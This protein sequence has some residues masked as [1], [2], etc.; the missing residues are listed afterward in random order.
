VNALPFS[1]GGA[2]LMQFFFFWRT[3]VGDEDYARASHPAARSSSPPFAQSEGHMTNRL[4]S[5]SNSLLLFLL[6]SLG[7]NGLSA[8]SGQTDEREPSSHAISCTN[9]EDDERTGLV[10]CEEGYWHR[11]TAH[12]CTVSIP[13][14]E[15]LTTTN[16]AD[17]CEFDSDCPGPYGYC[18][19]SGPAPGPFYNTCFSGCT[20]DDDCDQNQVCVCDTIV[21]TC[22][23]ATCRTDLDCED[24]SLC[25]ATR[26]STGSGCGFVFE[27]ACTGPGDEC[28]LDSDCGDSGIIGCISGE[29]GRACESLGACGRPFL[30]HGAARTSLLEERS[31]WLDESEA[32]FSDG[33]LSDEV[34]AALNKHFTRAGLMEHASIA[35]FARF[36]LQLLALGAPADLTVATNEAL[37]DETRH[38]RICFTLARRFGQAPLGPAALPVYGALDQFDMETTLATTLLEGCLGETSAAL[39]ARHASLCCT[40]ESIQNALSAIADDESRHAALAFRFVRFALQRNP[41]LTQTVVRFFDELSQQRFKETTIDDWTTHHDLRAY[42]VLSASERSA[43]AQDAARSIVV[44]T[45]RALLQEQETRRFTTPLGQQ[46]RS[47]QEHPART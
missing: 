17:H 23:N 11:P 22:A 13:R 15:P 26:R 37:V 46:P 16:E 12:A 5:E 28:I 39:E 42:G 6:A 30:I 21:G 36:Q 8:C 41:E 32:Q 44:P 43:L 10:A 2:T 4:S 35:A 14:E 33:A 40:D 3:D 24:G 9:P 38:A 20:S 7:F 45:L 27:L 47:I 31:D 34:R 1:K 18:E 19:F 29:N 25:V